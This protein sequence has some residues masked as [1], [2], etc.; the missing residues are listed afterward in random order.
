MIL[1]KNI[2]YLTSITLFIFAMCLTTCN[3]PRTWTNPNDPETELSPDAWAPTN[4][5][6]EV[7]N[8]SEIKLTWEQEDT[9]ISGFRIS[10]KDSSENFNQIAEVDTREYT[11]SGLNYGAE[12]IYRVTA[13][14][15]DNLSGYTSSDTINTIFPAP[16]NLVATPIDDQRIHLTWT[17]N[18]S[19]ESGYRIERSAGGVFTQLAEVDANISEFIDTGLILDVEYNYRVKSF[20]VENGS[21]F[22]NSVDI[23]L[24]FDCESAFMGVAFINGCD[25]CV[26]GNTGLNENYCESITDID[27]NEYGT[28]ILGNQTWMAEN[29]KV[30][31]Y[32]DGTAIPTGHS[33]SDWASLTT[34]GYAVYNN[35]EDLGDTFGFLYNG[36]AV[37]DNRNIAPEGWHVPSDDEWKELELYLGM[38]ESEI[39]Y[40]GSRGSNEGSKLAGNASLWFNGNLANN[41]EF[42]TS[43]FNAIPS[44]IRKGNNGNFDYQNIY[45]WFWSSS[46]SSDTYSWYRRLYYNYSDVNRN[47]YHRRTGLSIRCVMD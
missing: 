33:N 31:K 26:G 9:R 7:L 22:S 40:T 5:Q 25:Y 28:I 16:S 47:V 12:Y 6:V 3:E 18:C 20:T 17:D 13:F 38:N 27:G 15:N 30:S 46:V 11:D 24:Y 37:D 34:G 29:L 41:V 45:S 10:R 44:G 2:K 1:Y 32:R 14:T 21:N 19:F 8:D 23:I 43:G 42:G 39:N 4:L 35:V 36:F